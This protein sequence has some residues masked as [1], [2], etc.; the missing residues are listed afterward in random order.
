MI[1]KSIEYKRQCVVAT[2]KGKHNC[3]YCKGIDESTIEGA[4]VES[5]RLM[6]GDNKEVF[7]R[8]S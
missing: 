6:C 7:Y 5:Y 8:S 4:F 1:D 3:P 2:K